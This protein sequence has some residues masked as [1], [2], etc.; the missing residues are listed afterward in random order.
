MFHKV[1]LAA[2]LQHWE[3]PTPYACAARDVAIQ[4]TKG[5]WHPLYVLTVYTY[6]L[7]PLVQPPLIGPEAVPVSERILSAEEA[8]VRTAV[9]ARLRDYTLAIEHAGVAVVPVIRSGTPRD[10]VVRV[11]AEIGADC[12]VIGSHS[13]RHVVDLGGTAQA[14]CRRAP[15]PVVMVSPGQ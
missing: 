8:A 6:Q 1:L 7:A 12:L 9:A 2:A 13:K 14:I 15:V 4:L 10:E 11:V 3:V 5:T